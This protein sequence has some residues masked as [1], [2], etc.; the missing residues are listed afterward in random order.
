MRFLVPHLAWL[1][2]WASICALFYV[3]V[4]YL[5]VLALVAH[6]RPR[7]ACNSLSTESYPFLSVLI[8]AFNEG[9][10]IRRKLENTLALD[11]PSD[12]FEVVVV[13]D[14]SNDKTE[15]IVAGFADP[16][17]H[18]VGI[19]RRSGKTNAQN[20]GVRHCRGEFIVFSDA[21]TIYDKNAL[22]RIVEP[23]RDPSV[24]AV[25]GRYR[26]VSDLL[27]SPSAAGSRAFWDYENLIKRL[28]ARISTLTGCSGCIYSVRARLY[29]CMPDD[30]CSDLVLPLKIIQRGYR[31]ALAESALA[32]EQATASNREE[33][34]MRVR[35]ATHGIASLIAMRDLLRIWRHGWISFQLFSHKVLRWC[36]PFFL[37]GLLGSSIMLARYSEG[38]QLLLTL[39]LIF[40]GIALLTIAIPLRGW[41]RLLGVFSYFCILNS[42]VFGGILEVCRGNKFVTW[43]SRPRL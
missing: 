17:V 8:P 40:Y 3:Y 24:G 43:E 22:R 18:L 13:S 26:Y 39:Q 32:Y 42:A 33:F 35:V 16:R 28:Q 23:Y 7:K 25:S 5:L 14:G 27:Q 2:F 15:S 20:V 19:G 11:Y 34:R 1:M 36:V 37:L 21:T 6:I 31:V 9:A 41:W 10:N 38:V 12:A 30:A 4:G 29:E